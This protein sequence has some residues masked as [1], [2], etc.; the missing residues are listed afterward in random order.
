MKNNL[1]I[2]I[3][4]ALSIT[5]LLLNATD[6]NASYEEKTTRGARNPKIISSDSNVYV[7]WEE[8]T[9]PQYFDLY[10]RKSTDNG[11]T[12]D[13]VIDLTQ[14]KSFYPRPQI[15]ASK[16]NVYIIWEDRGSPDGKPNVYFRKSNDGGNIFDKTVLLSLADTFGSIYGPIS[17]LE[18]NGIL[19]VFMSRWN[20]QTGRKKIIYR[21]SHDMGNTFDGAITLFEFDKWYSY[22]DAVAENGVI[23]A[24]ADGD[25]RYEKPGKILYRKINPDQRLGEII[26][27]NN[28]DS[29]IF[30][31]QISVSGE[32][33]YV[34]WRE[35]INGKHSL[36]FTKSKN[37]GNSFDKP[38]RLNIDPKSLDVRWSVGSQISSHGN[39]VY[40]SWLEEYLED[41]KQVFHE[42]FAKSKDSGSTFRI[43]PH[44][45][46]AEFSSYDRIR[47]VEEND[48]LY[49]M[50]SGVKN[51]PFNDR[52]LYFTKSEDSG[53]TFAKTKELTG[54]TL[55][56][57]ESPQIVVE[58]NNV[59]IAG[60]GKYNTH[61]ILYIGSNDYGNA[62]GNIL[63]L[64]P[65]GNPKDCFGVEEPVDSPLKQ[66]KE[67]TAFEDVKCEQ[68]RSKG[69]ILTLKKHDGFPACVA[70]NSFHKLLE[71]GVILENSHEILG[72]RA[73]EKFIVS[74]PTY[75]FDGVH[76]SLKLEVSNIRKSIPPV[77][78]INGTFTSTH[79]GYGDRTDNK[80]EKINDHTV[81]KVHIVVSQ[82]NKIHLATLDGIWDEIKQKSINGSPKY[83]SLKFNS[84]PTVSTLLTI[85]DVIDNKG[86]VPVTVT[87]ISE[88]VDD[89]IT[90]WG[91]QLLG[92]HGDNRGIEWDILPR[93]YRAWGILD[94]NGNDARLSKE[95]FAVRS[96]LLLYPI[97]CDGKE[98]IVGESGPPFTIPIKPGIDRVYA[99]S[100]SKGI[101]PDPEGIYTIKFVSLFKTF[102]EF[103]K[104]AEIIENET[105][106]CVMENI[107]KDATHAYYTR[108][109]FRLGASS[110]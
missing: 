26:Q 93:A 2:L 103:S 110:R 21:A 46:D 32:N 9:N 18:S 91:F 65:N 12:F 102:V 58:K 99:K 48:I 28:P 38:V 47:M 61:C 44:P 8:S 71:S 79:P 13:K 17:M 6:G 1:L 25:S 75:S 97:Y 59:H 85:G 5:V 67:G 11:N 54:N 105:K 51:P 43:T 87:E 89:K 66:I 36:S 10:F 62:F 90:V 55:A 95:R 78:T 69:Y 96:V 20:P 52:T 34:I 88:K 53:S 94:E 45:L 64:S 30:G 33:V 22:F 31:P 16:N 56:A 104:A 83:S 39:S 29:S 82:V 49:F 106:L 70:A 37:N 84:G 23:Y 73:A 14:G 57:F 63:N 81:H 74:H 109:I 40:V 35:I 77:I 24:V 4:I 107:I 101:L 76:N 42:W 50:A 41:N 3:G 15:F 68:D 80:H 98:R 108:I 100:S 27:L 60:N 72:L 19:Y 7:V 86:L 92:Y